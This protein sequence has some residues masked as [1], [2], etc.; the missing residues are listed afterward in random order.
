MNVIFNA[1]GGSKAYGLDTPE[2]DTDLRG[3]FLNTDLNHIIGLDKYEHQQLVTNEEDNKYK[4]LRRFFNLLRVANSEAIE[5]LFMDDYIFCDPLFAEIR[6]QR[7]RLLDSERLYKCLLGYMKG[8]LARANGARTGKLGGKRKEAIDSY[9]FSPKNFCQL[10]RLSWAGCVFFTKGYFPVDVRKEDSEFADFL[11]QIKTAPQ[12]FTVDLLNKAAVV[13]EAELHL[14]YENRKFEYKFDAD[15][16]NEM[17]LLAYFPILSK[18]NTRI[19]CEAHK[20]F[21]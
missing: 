5:M 6:S 10:L 4:E 18:E 2:S 7:E 8:E 17:I 3:V 1:L 12:F 9:G 11:L 20:D 21:V 14:A 15:Y 19:V 16:A 13:A